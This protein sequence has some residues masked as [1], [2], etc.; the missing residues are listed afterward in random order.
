MMQHLQTSQE[1]ITV[2]GAFT[3]TRTHKMYGMVQVYVFLRPQ[4]DILG[5][6]LPASRSGEWGNGVTKR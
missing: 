6:V 4:G 5:D 3:P 2:R 1:P